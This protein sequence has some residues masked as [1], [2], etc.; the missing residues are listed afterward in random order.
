[1]SQKYK[2]Y[3]CKYIHVYSTFVR[4]KGWK[5]IIAYLPCL[6]LPKLSRQVFLFIQKRESSF[7]PN[8]GNLGLPYMI[9]GNLEE[10]G[11]LHWF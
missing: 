4:K 6:A 10:E 1:M 9:N 5:L 8:R 2:I 11:K 7:E 3:K